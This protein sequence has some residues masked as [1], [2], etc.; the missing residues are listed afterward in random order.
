MERWKKIHEFPRYSVSDHGRIRNDVSG[1]IMTETENQY[2][3]VCVGLMADGKQYHRSVPKLVAQAFVPHPRGPFDTPINLDG[4]RHNNHVNNIAWRPRWFAVLYNRQFRER[5][6]NP[7]N[8]P[9]IMVDQRGNETFHENSLEAAKCY[10]LLEKEVV[11]AYLNSTV[12][13]PTHH[14]VFTAAPME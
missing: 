1:H 8:V 9:I 14:R 12:T 11:L 4:D 2:G 10:G 6:H 7:I 5:Y 3:V 13:W